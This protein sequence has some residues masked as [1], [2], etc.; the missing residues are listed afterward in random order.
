VIM[1][2]SFLYLVAAS[3]LAVAVV[4]LH[5]FTGS[6]SMAEKARVVPTP[7][8]DE[9]TPTAKSEVAVFAG[10]CF[11]GVQGVYQHVKGV[12]NAVSGY[13]GGEKKTAEY[14]IVGTGSTGHAES[15]QVTFDPRVVSYGRLLQIFFSVVHDPTQ[16]DRQGP[17]TGPQY[18][19]AL[20]PTSAEQAG[21]A[22]AYIAQLD[23]A[24]V[25]DRPLVTRVEPGRTF[26]PAEEYHQDFLAQNPTHPY[27]RINDLP[28]I[29]ELK[30]LFPDAYRSQAV[31]VG[32]GR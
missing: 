1:P 11:W 16:L 32:A 3:A 25:F 28:K 17:D 12:T 26:Y 23:Q 30:R 24:H 22:K 13:A 4:T 29:D 14:E 8:V 2:R 7:A 21:I 27:I 9:T 20:F 19:S 10:G 18:R 6:A 5:G 15:V 31:L